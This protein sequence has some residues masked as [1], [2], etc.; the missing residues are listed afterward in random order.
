MEREW[1]YLQFS[2]ANCK[3]C[4]KCIRGCPVKSILFSS[5]KAHVEIISDD[6]VICGQCFVTCPQKTKTIRDDTPRVREMIS[7]G[8]RV[9]ASLAPSY[10]ANFPGASLQAMEASLEKLGFCG[11]GETA[12]GATAV[13]KEYE[14]IIADGGNGVVISSCCHSVNLM[15]QKY[16]PEALPSLAPVASPMRAHCEAI[17]RDHPE[18]K[19]VF[20]G[21]C[22][23]KKA[24]A[25]LYPGA[26]DCAITFEELSRWFEAEGVSPQ[27]AE[28]QPKEEAGRARLFPVPGGILRSM[29]WR[30]ADYSYV[31]ADGMPNCIN[32]IRGVISGEVSNCFIEMSACVGSCIGGPAM[33]GAGRC[34]A[35]GCVA[36][37][38]RAG[39][40]DLDD[41][42]LC[43]ED[44]R[45]SFA[46]MPVRKIFPGRQAIEETLRAM[47]KKTPHDELNCG[48]CGYD[49]C[50]DKAVAVLLGKA[51]VGMCL[52][53]L[54]ERAQSFSDNIIR[55]T[56]N[57]I[58]VLDESL[59]IQQANEAAC[60]ILNIRDESD[61]KGM[62]AAC[63]LDPL[64]ILDAMEKGENVYEKRAH[65]VEYKKYVMQSI[66][67]DPDH[68]IIIVLMRDITEEELSRARKVEICGET[69]GI[70]DSVIEHQMRTVQEIASL[71]GETAA[72]TQ[73]ALTRL[74]DAIHNE[75]FLH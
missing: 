52:P 59:T 5:R 41:S 51:D 26:V 53:Y 33:S 31:V 12:V 17:K 18:A 38:R 60:R 42:R 67:H 36:I 63:V 24:E 3:H 39:E 71:L 13:K 40:A 64:P 7:G 68:S 8:A 19:A 55:N 27:Q 37:D 65:L 72:E 47:G 29:A 9:Y 57:G 43:G 6:C 50:R 46:P 58:I 21:P 14:R 32:A 70:T 56:P 15:I 28:P 75:Q 1:D 2:G 22:I 35:G 16:F 62:E 10:A 34:L 69:I 20:I 48:S 44:L 11:V 30:R 25:E 61:V 45:Q 23:S 66:I 74:K 73:I 49:T 4:Y 54:Q